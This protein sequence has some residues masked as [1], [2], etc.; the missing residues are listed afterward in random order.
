MKKV[1]LAVCLLGVAVPY[2]W[3][4]WVSFGEELGGAPY[5]VQLVRSDATGIELMVRFAG[6]ELTPVTMEGEEYSQAGM[7]GLYPGV[8]IG[9]P[10][11]PRLVGKVAIPSRAAVTASVAATRLVDLGDRRMAPVQLPATDGGDALPFV[12]KDVYYRSGGAYPE[13]AMELGD[14]AIWR[15][16]R[17]VPVIIQPLRWEAASGRLTGAAMVQV[18]LDFV[19]APTSN[20]KERAPRPVSPVWDALYRAGIWNYESAAPPRES[21]LGSRSLPMKYLVIADDSLMTG[22]EDFAA[23]YNYIGIGCEVQPRSSAGTTASA[24]KSFIQGYYDTQGIEYCLLVGDISLVPIGS[25]SGDPSDHYYTLLEGSDDYPEIALGRLV[26]TSSAQVEH[27][28]QK[29]LNYM[30]SP[31]Q[32]NWTQ[33]SI[34][35]AHEQ[36]YPGD[37]TQ[38]KNEIRTFS[39]GIVTPVFDTCYPPE[40]CTKA[41]VTSAI[42]EGRGLVNYRGHGSITEWSWSPGWSTSDIYALSNGLYMPHTFN[43]CCENAWIDSAQETICEAWMNAG[44][45]GTGGAVTAL[46]ASRDSYTVP[47]HDFDKRLYTALFDEGINSIGYLINAGRETMIDMGDLGIYNTYIYLLLGDPALDVYTLAP[48]ELEVDYP[49][50]I[51]MGPVDLEVN[52]AVAGVPVPDA[53]VCCTKEGEI[54][55]VAYTNAFGVAVVSIEPLTP[56]YIQVVTTAHNGLPNEGSLLA[57]TTGCGVVMTDSDMYNCSD[58]V[59]IKVWDA[60]LNLSPG[61]VDLAQ[62]TVASLSHPTPVVVQLTES[63]PDTSQFNGAVMLTDGAPGL[64]RVGVVHG[65]LVTVTYEDEDCDGAPQTVTAQ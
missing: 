11:L 47:N 54:S 37:Y 58:V 10:D 14:P 23:W 51:P 60:D 39:Y 19:D 50:A 21:R 35:A 16:L 17:V 3:A 52:V 15:E 6:V 43:I 61:A 8:E 48:M 41:H 24:I 62:V 25:Y 5:E 12:I 33:K 64:S 59:E 29:A 46:G 27:Q 56:G 30:Q 38:C 22:V 57:L 32:D 53:R 20:V 36:S 49:D 31:P 45:D 26:T 13:N 28:L 34:L 18:R 42:N 63:G 7:A 44:S 65:D 4:E 1:L 40:G 2:A 55:E 9:M